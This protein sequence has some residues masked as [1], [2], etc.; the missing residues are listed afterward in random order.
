MAE[1][2]VASNDIYI[3]CANEGEQDY[4]IFKFLLII[5]KKKNHYTYLS[6]RKSQ[7][8]WY[9]YWLMF[10]IRILIKITINFNE[11]SINTETSD[12]FK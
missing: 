6:T 2:A 10:R 11:N 8:E 3:K 9:P 7:T 1:D 12:G 4:D 5:M